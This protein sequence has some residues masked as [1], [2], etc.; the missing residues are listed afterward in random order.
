M[1][2]A[3]VELGMIPILAQ[4]AV[5]TMTRSAE[6]KCLKTGFLLSHSLKAIDPT[7]NKMIKRAV[8]LKTAFCVMNVKNTKARG[9]LSMN[10]FIIRKRES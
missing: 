6:P 10:I 2:G 9:Y 4:I 8:L 3:L 5:I 1:T 7:K